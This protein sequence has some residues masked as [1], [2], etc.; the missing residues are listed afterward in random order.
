ML[1]LNG[2]HLDSNPTPCL[3]LEMGHSRALCTAGH[4]RFFCCAVSCSY[5]PFARLCCFDLDKILISSLVNFKLFF[6]PS[7][8]EGFGKVGLKQVPPTLHPPAVA[9]AV[10]LPVAL[11][12]VSGR[13]SHTLLPSLSWPLPAHTN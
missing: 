12:C 7:D 5:R 6:F 8:R 9:C 1:F 2:N 3:L 13:G 10:E 11:L 4:G